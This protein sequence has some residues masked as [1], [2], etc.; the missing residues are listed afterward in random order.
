MDLPGRLGGGHKGTNSV[1]KLALIVLVLVGVG[2]A[3]PTK[4]QQI[5]K[6]GA[7][8]N[9]DNGSPYSYLDPKS[10]TLQGVVVDLV[11]KIARKAGFQAAFEPTQFRALIEAL[12]ASRI[13]LIAAM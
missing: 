11:T 8:P 10:N 13:D 4:A 3:G 2:L 5:L 6:I 7:P 9:P 12:R 1:R